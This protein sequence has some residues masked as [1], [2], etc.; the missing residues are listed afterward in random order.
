MF[1]KYYSKVKIIVLKANNMPSIKFKNA[2]NLKHACWYCNTKGYFAKLKVSYL[3]LYL[4]WF[5]STFSF[6]E[7]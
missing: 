6:P 4:P 7:I 3:Y 2:L 5:S 1:E